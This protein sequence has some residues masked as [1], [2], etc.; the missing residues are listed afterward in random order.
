MTATLGFLL[1]V[2]LGVAAFTD[3]WG[4]ALAVG[5]PALGVP[6]A[7]YRMAPGSLASRIAM[8]CGFMVFSALLIQQSHGM[9]EAHFGIFV[10]LALLLYYRDWR[11]VVA[12]SAL[13]AVHHLAFNTMQASGLG[14]FILANGP[15]LGVIALHAVYVVFEAGM[16]ILLGVNMRREALESAQVA[17]LAER[18]GQGD[19]ATRFDAGDLAG[20]PLLAKTAEMQKQLAATIGEVNAQTALVSRTAEAL[21]GGSRNM[22]AAMSQQTDATS[23]MAAGVEELTV[24]INHISENA[25]E[26]QRLAQESEQSA[27]SGAG[28]VKSSIGEMRS[29]ADAIRT[30][31]GNMDHLGTQFDNVANVVGLIKDIAGQTN[32]LAL[33][34]AIEAAR[35]G[36]QGR[37]FA[38]VA[39]EVRKLAEHT[40]KATEDINRMM[41]EI[42][43]SKASALAS[44]DEAVTKAESGVNL[45]GAAGDSID[46]IT[47][48]AHRVQQVVAEI[49]NALRE[50]TTAASEIA[51]NVERI[52]QMAESSSATA[53]SA[54][55]DS[56]QLH[57]TAGA[58][59]AAVERFRLV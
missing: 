19:L 37:G 55:S 46:T 42:Q 23:A 48:Q 20:Q 38:V 36:E 59:H 54:V 49:N 21:A 40:S 31:S 2:S 22:G 26:A 15:S 43:G 28:V 32:L 5:L 16:L 9:V 12:A 39:D 44:I 57:R 25:S 8:A 41:Q 51:R 24:S 45:A 47:S 29:I 11:P 30:L 52:S 53:S 7:L 33:N 50:Q 35:A 3:S 14:V 10:L 34:A 56:D 58:L 4:V 1:L 18:I 13:I 27:S 6:F 17:A